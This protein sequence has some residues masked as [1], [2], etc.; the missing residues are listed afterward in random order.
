MVGGLVQDNHVRFGQQHLGQRHTLGLATGEFADGQRHVI[1]AELAEHLARHVAAVP[2][3]GRQ[4]GGTVG[5]GVVHGVEVRAEGRLLLQ[6]A[7]ADAV[8]PY[9]RAGVG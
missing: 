1:D 5:S 4:A 9:H 7:Y 6:I 2:F 8:A 3:A